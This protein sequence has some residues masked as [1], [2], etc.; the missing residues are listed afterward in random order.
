MHTV[1]PSLLRN[2]DSA[3]TILFV[4][5]AILHLAPIMSVRYLD[6]YVRLDGTWLIAHRLLLTDW[7]EDREVRPA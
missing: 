5:M 2:P 3:L 1:R 7:T 4:I 6:T